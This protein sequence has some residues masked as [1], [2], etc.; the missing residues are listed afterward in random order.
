[1]FETE[2]KKGFTQMC[3]SF[4]FKVNHKARVIKSRL[5]EILDIIYVRTDTKN[6][7]CIM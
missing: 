3:L 5:S 6:Q 2:E 1:M 4:I 7:V